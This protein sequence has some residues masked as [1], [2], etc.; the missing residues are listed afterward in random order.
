MAKEGVEYL[1]DIGNFAELGCDAK[2]RSDEITEPVG[3]H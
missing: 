3:A 1:F 2:Q